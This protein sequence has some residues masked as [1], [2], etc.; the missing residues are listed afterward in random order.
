MTF[1]LS[2]YQSGVI[3]D[4]INICAVVIS[5]FIFFLKE[6]AH[7]TDRSNPILFGHFA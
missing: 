3:K 2:A 4:K 1:P 7:L 6:F 5:L